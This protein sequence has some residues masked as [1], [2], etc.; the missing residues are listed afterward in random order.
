MKNTIKIFVLFA[1]LSFLHFD[2]TAQE[3]NAQKP[4][5]EFDL[6][7]IDQFRE[8]KRLGRMVSDFNNVFSSSQINELG[9]ILQDYEIRTTRQIVVVTVDNIDPYKDIQEMAT[10][11]GDYWGVGMKGKDN[12]LVILFC[13]PCRQ[14]GI[15][16]GKGTELILTDDI[17]KEVIDQV[18]I[19][20]FRN[21]KFY[22]GIKKGTLALMDKWN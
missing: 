21:G 5:T 15:A 14:V 22:Q 16:T 8:T 12:G 18:M 2:A 20:E 4:K 10:A 11:L 17:S 6:S 9:K 7:S 19:P 1:I 3:K 13:K